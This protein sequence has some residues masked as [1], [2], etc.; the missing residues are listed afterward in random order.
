MELTKI[1][2]SKCYHL[3]YDL[4]YKQRKRVLFLPCFL[5]CLPSGVTEL[6]CSFVLY[7]TLL[8]LFPQ[9]TLFHICIMVS[10]GN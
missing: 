9:V 5:F 10:Q 8:V 6:L 4:S 1:T 2:C 3:K 7:T